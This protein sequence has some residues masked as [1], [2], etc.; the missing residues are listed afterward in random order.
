VISTCCLPNMTVCASSTG[1]TSNEHP[2]VE[3]FKAGSMGDDMSA[4]SEPGY[5]RTSISG[6]TFSGKKCL[7]GTIFHAI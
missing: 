7:S 5:R 2:D 4:P 1:P 3:D 6:T